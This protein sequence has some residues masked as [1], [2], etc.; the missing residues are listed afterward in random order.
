MIASHCI[1]P[2]VSAGAGLGTYRDPDF[3]GTTE[4]F[5]IAGKNQKFARSGRSN[6][7]ANQAR[8]GLEHYLHS[9]SGFSLDLLDHIE[10]ARQEE[11]QSHLRFG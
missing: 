11:N 1:T 3:T 5:R 9:K 10:H 7:L 4:D 6:G 8:M 2:T